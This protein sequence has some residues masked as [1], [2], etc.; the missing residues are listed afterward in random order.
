MFFDFSLSI[1]NLWLFSAV[2]L[3]LNTGFLF[4]FPK[5]NIGKF[6]KMPKVK[7][8]TKLNQITY[9]LLFLVSIVIPIKI[10]TM[11]LYIGLI[12]FSIGIFFYTISLLYFAISEYHLPVTGGIYKF[13][14]HPVYVSF[15]IINLGMITASTS[16]IVFIIAFLHFYSLIFII[17]EE[18]KICEK[19]YGNLYSEYKQKTRKFL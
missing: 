11:Y 12:L 15:F 8:Y 5:Y 1:S 13:S 9:Y 7:N 14:R 2:F 17:K 18:E 10:G 16:I 19:Q 6:I 4:L 3:L